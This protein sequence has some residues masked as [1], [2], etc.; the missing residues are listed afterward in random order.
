VRPIAIVRKYVVREIVV[1]PLFSLSFS[2]SLSSTSSH[3]K[4]KVCEMKKE[5]EC[6]VPLE[7]FVRECN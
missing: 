5:R 7:D 3:S 1:H 4:E 2:L 6:A